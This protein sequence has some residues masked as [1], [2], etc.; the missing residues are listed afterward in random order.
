MTKFGYFS[1]GFVLASVLILGKTLVYPGMT[2]AGATPHVAPLT[3]PA[4]IELHRH[5][6]SLPT[7]RADLS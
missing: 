6:P 7:V 1:A 5:E 2:Q 3:M 4:T